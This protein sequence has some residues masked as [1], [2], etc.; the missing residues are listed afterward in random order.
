VL[1]LLALGSAVYAGG[2]F[3]TIG[4]ASRNRLAA[5]DTVMGLATAWDPSADDS[6]CALYAAGPVLY[7]GGAFGSLGNVARARAG[8]IELASG[9]LTA[10][11]P[12]ADGTVRALAIRNRVAYLGGAFS[13]VA[14]LARNQLCATDTIGGAVLWW[15][16]LPNGPANAFFATRRDVYCGGAFNSVSN[17]PAYGLAQVEA[18]RT[19]TIS[20]VS[21]NEGNTGDTFMGFPVVL[22]APAQSPI[23]VTF[24]TADRSAT[25]S[26][27]DYVSSSGSV[28]FSTGDSLKIAQVTVRGDRLR[29]P[30][31]SL[32]VTLSNPSGTII[33]D[34]SAVGTILN[35]DPLPGLSVQDVLRLEGNTGTRA[36]V[37]GIT[38]S[39]PTVSTITVHYATADSSA[40]ASDQ[41]YL[42]VSGTVTIPPRALSDT[43]IHVSVIG[44]TIL[45]PKETFLVRLSDPVEARLVD[46][47]GLGTVINDD[48][49]D[50]VGE[51]S[52][53]QFGLAPVMP[54]PAHAWAQFGFAIPRRLRVRLQVLDLQGRTIATLANEVLEAGRY[55]RRWNPGWGARRAAP[56]VY[57]VRWEAGGAVQ[58]RRFVCFP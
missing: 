12:S 25:V 16:P 30:D 53:P 51:G 2:T 41:D 43:T 21:A 57:L 38:L 31:E 23:S 19:V 32:F 34:S 29:E 35:D 45:E 1:A 50:A 58:V 13:H 47:T 54:N 48:D 22:S 18:V 4:G 7:V 20:D 40:Q 36:F 46:S 8:A 5:L 37:F 28:G 55:E 44:D 52:P 27:G 56:G 14:G 33:A 17:T 49:V 15:S 3:T 11:N 42:P 9:A 39:N 24:A 10:W 6:V 26:D